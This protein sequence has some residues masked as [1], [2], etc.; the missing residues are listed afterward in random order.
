[1][2]KYQL[3]LRRAAMTLL[4]FPLSVSIQTLSFALPLTSLY[5]LHAASVQSFT[6]ADLKQEL[7]RL[8][9]EPPI[10]S[11]PITRESSSSNDSK[12]PPAAFK[13]PSLTL[14]QTKQV[15][16]EINMRVKEAEQLMQNQWRVVQDK[17]RMP[18]S[19]DKVQLENA[20][21]NLEVKKTL[22][23]K[24]INSPSLKSPKV[25]EILIQVLSKD[26]IQASD[27]AALQNI[28]DRERPY[29][30]P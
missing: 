20:I 12:D 25:R 6:D 26:L 3:S 7:R 24:F 22:A 19:I 21:T 16:Q 27:L 13:Y 10:P 4:F 14:E 30:Y 23:A 2:R 11:M 17:T 9:Q 28:V 8:K 1:M 5:Q 15:N 18:M 29:T